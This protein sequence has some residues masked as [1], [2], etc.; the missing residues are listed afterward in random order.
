MASI[1]H[2]FTNSDIPVHI[3]LEDQGGGPAIRNDGFQKINV[4]ELG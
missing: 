2:A 3:V 4:I 1:V